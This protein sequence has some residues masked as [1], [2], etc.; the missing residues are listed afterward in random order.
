MGIVYSTLHNRSDGD[1]ARPSIYLEVVRVDGNPSKY[2]NTVILLVPVTIEIEPSGFV[3]SFVV[4]TAS[5]VV[6]NTKFDKKV[7]VTLSAEST[8][9]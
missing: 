5:V 6:A 8:F 3:T 1:A 4:N 2:C 9:T 7:L